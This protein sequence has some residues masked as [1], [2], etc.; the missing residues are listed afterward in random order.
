M[1]ENNHK[2]R[3]PIPPFEF[4]TPPEYFNEL[5]EVILNRINSE[6]NNK[7]KKPNFRIIQWAVAAS[8]ILIIGVAFFNYNTQNTAPS[9][10]INELETSEI[11]SYLETIEL[12]DEDLLETLN[13]TEISLNEE[14]QYNELLEDI[15]DELL[16]QYE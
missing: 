13:I 1:K 7:S 6:N 5:N 14:I 16:Y 4:N 11:E 8:V 3:E 15:D 9:I 2:M 12:N 10:S